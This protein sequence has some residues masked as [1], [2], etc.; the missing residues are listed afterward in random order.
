MK[1]EEDRRVYIP[2]IEKEG[3]FILPNEIFINL[4]DCNSNSHDIRIDTDSF[5]ERHVIMLKRI[6]NFLKCPECDNCKNVISNNNKITDYF[7]H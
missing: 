3:Y 6:V 7:K 2:E 1:R 5:C 4:P